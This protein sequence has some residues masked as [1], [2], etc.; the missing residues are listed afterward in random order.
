[1]F[2][3][4]LLVLGVLA[5]AIQLIPYG[6]DHQNPPVVTEPDWDSPHT[7]DLVAAACFDCHSNE[8][9][10][11]WYSYV[12]PISWLIQGDVLEGRDELNFSD[13]GD[14]GEVEDLTETIVDGEMPPARYRILH[15]MARLSEDQVA[16]LLA[17]LETTF[18]ISVGREGSDDDDD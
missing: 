8:T 16:Q 11:P 14:E 15:P 3:R 18:G 12:A 9:V 6:R 2:K 13:W 17:G 7:R 1:M 10:W 4:T 5:L